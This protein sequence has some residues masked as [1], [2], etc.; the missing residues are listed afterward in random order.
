MSKG[1]M[2]C[3]GSCCGCQEASVEATRK[4]L[5]TN[6]EYIKDASLNSLAELLTDFAID[7]LSK[8]DWYRQNLGLADN[9]LMKKWLQAE[10]MF[11]KIGEIGI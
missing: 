10:M 1:C 7:V 2:N 3:G 5:P 8:P 9:T 6:Y 11:E 4:A